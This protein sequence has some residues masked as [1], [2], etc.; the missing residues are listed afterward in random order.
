MSAH[1]GSNRLDNRLKRR[2]LHLAVLLSTTAAPDAHAIA[3]RCQ[4]ERLALDDHGSA[5][6]DSPGAD[7]MQLPEVG[8]GSERVNTTGHLRLQ[9]RALRGLKSNTLRDGVYH[10]YC[11]HE[12][13]KGIS[14]IFAVPHAE[15]YL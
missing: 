6:A 11:L 4:L 1:S 14:S 3:G 8:I 9:G 12:D 5:R 13:R 15:T 7:D 10:E 2:T